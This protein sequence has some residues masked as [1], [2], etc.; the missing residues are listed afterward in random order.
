[1]GV[2]TDLGDGL[3][4][5]DGQ[6]V[7]AKVERVVLA[8]E[9]YEPNIEVQWIPPEVRRRSGN[10][11][12]AAFKIVYHDPNGPDMILFHVKDEEDFDERVLQ[13]IIANDQRNV[14]VT[15]DEYSAWEEA[16]R[17]VQEQE[18]LDKLEEAADIAAHVLKSP[19]NDYRV[20]KDLRI[21]DGIPYNA[22]HL[23]D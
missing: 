17:R 19:L 9:E 11:G 16:Q 3:V 22:A 21:K 12:L 8:I 10:P 5:I 1:M 4:V 20:N 23:K 18:I 7:S 14:N 13:R 6:F 2:H 15:W